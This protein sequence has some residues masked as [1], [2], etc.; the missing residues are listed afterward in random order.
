MDTRSKHDA[1]YVSGG[2]LSY[3]QIERYGRDPDRLGNRNDSVAHHLSECRLCRLT[4]DDVINLDPC[5]SRG[6][7]LPDNFWEDIWKSKS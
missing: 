4:L 1:G 5:L 7:R 6:K 2:H 3:S